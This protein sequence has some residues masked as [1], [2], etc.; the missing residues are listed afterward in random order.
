M[1]D[2]AHDYLEL[3]EVA[4]AITIE[5][6]GKIVATLPTNEFNYTFDISSHINQN[7]GEVHGINYIPTSDIL[8]QYIEVTNDF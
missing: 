1:T 6:D 2:K 5:K 7:G 3:V 8:L 4:T